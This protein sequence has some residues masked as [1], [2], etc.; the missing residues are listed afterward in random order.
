MLYYLVCALILLFERNNI[1]PR[2]ATENFSQ[3]YEALKQEMLCS[4]ER[5]VLYIIHSA[6]FICVVLKKFWIKRCSMSDTLQLFHLHSFYRIQSISEILKLDEVNFFIFS[7]P[8]PE[9]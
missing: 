4:F 5:F 2:T 8:H 6:I 1:Q 7:Y 9:A 3:A